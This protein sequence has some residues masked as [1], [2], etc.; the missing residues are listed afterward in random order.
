MKSLNKKLS[1]S[2]FHARSEQIPEQMQKR[3]LGG[4]D[5]D[6]YYG[7]PGDPPPHPYDQPG[8]EGENGYYEDG[9]PVGYSYQWVSNDVIWIN[10]VS[11]LPEIAIYG[12]SQGATSPSGGYFYQVG[13]YWITGIQNSNNSNPLSWNTLVASLGMTRQ[14]PW[15]IP[16]FLATSFVESELNV[17]DA[18]YINTITSFYLDNEYPDIELNITGSYGDDIKFQMGTYNLKQAMGIYEEA[19]ATVHDLLVEKGI[20]EQNGE[21]RSYGAYNQLVTWMQNGNSLEDF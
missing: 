7:D 19:Q 5:P 8:Y 21:I 16:A 11:Q 10:N 13:D 15:A 2:E 1:L 12:T 4:E 9:T 20:I 18:Q 14:V 17:S 6:D 3:I